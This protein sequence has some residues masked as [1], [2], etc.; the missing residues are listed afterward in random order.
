[1][2]ALYRRCHKTVDTNKEV[3][4]NVFTLCSSRYR[5]SSLTCRKTK[6]DKLKLIVKSVTKP[7]RQDQQVLSK[8]SIDTKVIYSKC[9]F[10]PKF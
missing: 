2:F 5:L 7:F 6:N 9:Y 10:C 4:E 8:L 3:K 1:M